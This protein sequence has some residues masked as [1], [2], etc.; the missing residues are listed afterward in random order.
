MRGISEPEVMAVVGQAIG[1][2][3][4]VPRYTQIYPDVPRISWFL[5]SETLHWAGLFDDPVE[6]NIQGHSLKCSYLE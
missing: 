1:A 6:S 2:T 5:G 3:M 4:S